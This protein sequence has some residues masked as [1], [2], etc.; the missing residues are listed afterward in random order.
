MLKERSNYFLKSTSLGNKWK[1]GGLL[2]MDLQNLSTSW[3]WSRTNVFG[4]TA[5][6]GSFSLT[7]I[8]FFYAAGLQVD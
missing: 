4:V 2:G 5:N 6:L 1:E 8:F 3:L 7:D